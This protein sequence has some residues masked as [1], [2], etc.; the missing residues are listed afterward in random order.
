MPKISN[1]KRKAALA[2]ADR[3]E[4]D[5]DEEREERQEHLGRVLARDLHHIPDV[6]PRRP[7]MDDVT[8]L[9]VDPGEHHV[10]VAVGRRHLGW[11][12]CSGAAGG[13][14]PCADG[15]VKD[16]RVPWPTGFGWFVSDVAELTPWEFVQFFRANIHE[17]DLVTVE[18][19]TL[20]KSLAL[21][22]V[23]SEMPTSKLIGWIEFSIK[24]WNEQ[25]T[26]DPSAPAAGRPEIQ[27]ESYPASIQDGTA[28]VMTKKGIPFR[29]PKTPDHARSAELH[30]WHTLIRAGLVEGVTL[31]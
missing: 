19:F 24:L 30:F 2:A 28:A 26:K 20:Y 31:A 29:S 4:R 12:P 27:Y 18:K 11:I 25:W 13:C 17:F 15:V 14:K 22:Q 10:G 9:A 6:L 3:V 5:Y 1:A 16:H 21:E 8:V 7:D 23:G